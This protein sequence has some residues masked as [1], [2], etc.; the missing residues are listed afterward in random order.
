M[1]G[2]SSRITARPSTWEASPSAWNWRKQGNLTANTMLTARLVRTTTGIEFTPTELNWFR[3]F[4]PS[5]GR[6]KMAN[7]R[8]ARTAK[9]PRYPWPRA[10]QRQ[11]CEY[12]QDH[13]A[14]NLK[15]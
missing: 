6:L 10:P 2:A 5:K 7:T 11:S 8:P 14:P 13:G 3:R 1:T 9:S 12:S 15:D 4:L